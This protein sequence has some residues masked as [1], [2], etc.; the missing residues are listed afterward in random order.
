VKRSENQK[1]LCANTEYVEIRIQAMK[2][3]KWQ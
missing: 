2:N 3:K 1:R